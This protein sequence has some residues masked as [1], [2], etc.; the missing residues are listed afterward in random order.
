MGGR[1]DRRE[2]YCST[3]ICFAGSH[4][5]VL[6]LIPQEVTLARVAI[7]EIADLPAWATMEE[8]ETRAVAVV[9]AQALDLSEIWER[10]GLSEQQESQQSFS[11][12]ASTEMPQRNILLLFKK[13][14]RQLNSLLTKK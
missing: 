8:K 3:T 6:L 2:A 13:S 9:V 10:R 11:I 1:E 12:R 4:S 5:V 14:R 7:R